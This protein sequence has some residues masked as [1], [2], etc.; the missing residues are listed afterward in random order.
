VLGRTIT[1]NGAL[2]Y[3]DVVDAALAQPVAP[4]WIAYKLVL[5]FGYVPETTDLLSNPDPLVASVASAL[6]AR[7][8]LKDAV[9]AMFLDD[10]FRYADASLG[11]QTVRQPIEMAVHAAK[12]LGFS[13]DNAQLMARLNAMSQKPFEPPNV[14]GWPIGKS[15][16]SPTTMIA[17]YDLGLTSFNLWAG[18]S[19]LA[20][21]LPASADLP[22][23]TARLGLAGLSAGT[24][25]AVL[26]YLSAAASSVPAAPERE[27]QT[28][29]LALLVSSPDWMVM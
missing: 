23:W 7:W 8:S 25:S 1:N 10:R 22:A 24:E 20:A 2:E 5:N 28:G 29:V 11:R 15:W 6:A 12:A 17:R 9:A 14:S 21:P 3:L 27:R 4:L 18:A 13:A 26:G 16:L 19:V